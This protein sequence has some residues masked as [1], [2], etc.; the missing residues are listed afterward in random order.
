MKKILRKHYIILSIMISIFIGGCYQEVLDLELGELQWSPELGVPLVD[1]EFTLIEILEA[2]PDDFNVSADENNT[3]VISIIDDSIF[4][5][6]GP[7]FYFLLDQSLDV[8]SLSLTQDQINEFNTN[9]SVTVNEQFQVE[10]PENTG[11]TAIEIFEGMVDLRIEENF[12]PDVR[13]TITEFTM[14]DPQNSPI[15]D[16][17]G[18]VDNSIEQ[19]I[20]FNDIGFVFDGTLDQRQVEF[21]IEY[22]IERASGFPTLVFEGNQ[23]NLFSDFVDQEFDVM[24]GDLPSGDIGTNENTIDT[25]FLNQDD[26]LGDIEYFLED[27]QFKITFKNTIGTQIRFDVNKFTSTK[28]GQET[29]QPINTSIPVEAPN[30]GEV[31]TSEADFDAIFKNLINNLPESVTL[32]I[33]GRLN[34]DN[35]NDNFQEDEAIPF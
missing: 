3:V 14:T 27:P 25:D 12:P 8:P 15:L 31:A 22:R 13:V 21:S 33:D 10:Y 1:S 17:D 35:S 16:Y 11:K 30:P 7:D 4:S 18:E 23:I 26:L 6:S 19:S 5:Q 34:P 24:Y 29:D 9:G 32:Q 28:D 20:P 2:S